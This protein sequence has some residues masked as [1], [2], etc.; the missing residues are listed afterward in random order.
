MKCKQ[1]T[2]RW[3]HDVWRC[4]VS[5]RLTDVLLEL[6]VRANIFVVCR[7]TKSAQSVL[8]SIWHVISEQRGV[9]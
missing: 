9:R 4:S 6:Y 3:L 2:T 5:G 7:H 8:S 1:Q